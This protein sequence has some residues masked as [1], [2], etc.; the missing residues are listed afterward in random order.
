[1]ATQNFINECKNPAYKNR[2]G[3][4]QIGD[5]LLYLTVQQSGLTVSDNLKIS[6]EPLN[7]D[8]FTGYLS[9]I[10]VSDTCYT[11]GAIIGTTNSKTSNIKI[12]DTRD[13]S[14]DVF[15][16]FVGVKYADTTTEWLNLGEY[17]TQEQ[18]ID[19][20]ANTSEIKGQ[21]ILY[22]L[23]KEYVCGITDWTNITVKDLL[24]DLCTSLDLELGNEHFINEDIP[25]SGNNYQKNCKFRDVLSDICEVAC[26]WAEYTDNKLWLKWFD[27]EVTETLDKS[28]Y[29]TLE[30][31]GVYGEVNCLVIKDS[32]FEGENVTIQDTQS[33]EVN[34]ETQIAIIDNQIL[35]T[36]ELRQQAIT[37]IWNRIQGFTYVDCRIV[38]YYGKPHLKRGSKISV[39]DVDGTYFTTYV[40]QHDFKYDGTF[41]SEISSPALTKEETAIKNTN[42]NPRQRLMNAEAQVLKAEARID[43]LVE[44]QEDIKEDLEENYYTKS[45]TDELI[46]DTAG[47]LI[48]KYTVGGGNNIFR[49]TGL[50]FESNDYTSGYEF[51]TGSVVKQTNNN[52]Q[53]KT[54]MYLQNSTL[55]QKQ[56]VTNDIYSVSFKYNKLNPLASATVTINENSYTLEEN[57]TFTQII[58]VTTNLI[59]VLFECDI[60][61]GYEIYELM[62]NYGE[63]PLNYSQNQNET[64]TDTV[65]ISEGI[66]ITD[67]R[68]S[69]VFKAN[70]DGIRICEKNNES[71]ITTQ[72]TD[73]GTETTTITANQGIIANLLIEEI[74]GQVWLTGIR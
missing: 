61:N 46:L 29:S 35:N 53:S 16:P 26:S 34:G 45:V 55:E 13:V 64:K 6:S 14:N 22:K 54:S 51:W 11:N 47:G 19:K 24:D 58:Q 72:F 74:D 66:K 28:Q 69:S 65:E 25:I 10:N 17:T 63:T 5:E 33:I 42:L 67:N 48:N 43:L 12:M 59:D 40:L 30:K 39:Q 9:E 70:S 23:E 21:D 1:M 36:E 3:K 73:K 31:N 27:D 20:T 49:N 8:K 50:Y 56:E 7:E 18:T 2:L 62:V 4:A 32:A 15:I 52:S 68:T 37:D 71:N 38:S 44:S 41:Y 60:D 57:G